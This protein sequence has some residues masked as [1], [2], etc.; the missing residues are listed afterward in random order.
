MKLAACTLLASLAIPL[1]DAESNADGDSGGEVRVSVATAPV[2]AER[3]VREAI[4]FGA[5][6]PD[7]DA[8]TAVA[9]PRAG[10]IER[11]LVRPGER[12]SAGQEL[13]EL[14]TAPAAQ[15]Q[16]DQARAAAKYA[17]EQ[18]ARLERMLENKLATREQIA[19]AQRDLAD[20]RAT[21]RSLRSVGA[22]AARQILRTPN[23]AIV[24]QVLVK[25]GDRA[26][27]DAPALALAALDGLIVRLGVEPEVAA[28]IDGGAAVKLAPVFDPQRVIAAHAKQVHAMLDPTT[29]LVDVVVPIPSEAAHALTLGIQM[30]G[31]IAL[32]GIDA[33]LVPRSALM[34]DESGDFVFTLVGDRA[35][36]VDVEVVL[37]RAADAAVR[38]ALAPG[39]AVVVTGAY[40]LSDGVRVTFDHAAP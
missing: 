8:A 28:Q 23:D 34:R 19:Q 22:N 32:G 26:A 16:W 2:R 33:L 11:V 24:T 6:E 14:G 15:S 20:A 37:E 30:R 18:L 27:A 39:T 29:R 12:V 13:L 17:E 21:E 3:V 9:L 31:A 38:G 5:V 7:P 1:A 10:V 35:R 36:R 4:A 40:Q 25:A